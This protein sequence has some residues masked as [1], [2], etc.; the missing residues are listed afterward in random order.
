[1]NLL[2]ILHLVSL[3]IDIN[4][5]FFVLGR[6]PR[7]QLNRICAVFIA[8][9]ATWSLC[10]CFIL[11]A[12][13]PSLAMLY[14]NIGSI[15]WYTAPVAS[16]W[17][18]LSLDSRDRFLKNKAFIVI[19]VI[20]PLFF[21]Y[22][23]WSGNMYTNIMKGPWGWTGSYELSIATYAYIFYYL[24][25]SAICLYL[26]A[27]VVL[28]AKTSRQKN[29]NR[30]LIV[31]GTAAIIF[32]T[33]T[34][35][36]LPAM[37]ITGFPVTADILFMIW[38][39]GIAYAVSRYRFMSLNPI[40]ASSNILEIISDSIVLLDME[41]KIV[42]TN[43]ATRAL[44]GLEDKELSGF[45]YSSIVKERDI[46]DQVVEEALAANRNIKRELTYVSKSGE[47]IPVLVTLSAVQD[48]ANKPCGFVVSALNMAEQRCA[49]QI[50][51]ESEEKYRSHFYNVNEVIFSYDVDFRINEV[52]PSVERSLG[53]RP[54]ELIGRTF[55]EL[56]IL[57]P[58]SLSQAASDAIH[59]LSGGHIELAEYQFIAKDG[60]VRFGE[61][62]GA[63]QTRDGKIV[64][65]ISV[66]RDITDRKLAESAREE[67]DRNYRL[68]AENTTDTVA[69][70]DMDLNI[71]WISDSSRETTGY[72]FE[73]QRALPLEKQMTAES[74]ERAMELYALALDEEKKGISP[75][76]RHYDIELEI[77]RKDGSTFWSENIFH[78]IREDQ[79]RA[80][81]ILM[82]GRDISRRKQAEEAL[83][84]EKH[85]TDALI[86][87]LP[88]TFWVVDDNVKFIRWNSNQEKVLGYSPDKLSRINPLKII[89][90]EDRQRVA[91]RFMEAFQGSCEEVETYVIKETGQ[92]VPYQLS[93]APLTVGGRQ[94]LMGF[95]I[96]ISARK[97]AESKLQKIMD[98][99]KRSNEELEQFAYVASHDLQE[100]L[101]MVSSYVQ[102]LEKRYRDKL[103]TDAIDFIN[104]AVDGSRRMQNL[105]NDLLSYSR[106]GS[107]GKP[108]QPVD[109]SAI[110]NAA[111]NNLQIAIRE[112]EAYIEHGELPRVTAD[113]GQMVQ[114]FKNLIGNAIKFH[115]KDSPHVIVNAD[116][117][118]GNWIFSVKDNGIGISRQFFDRIFM[119]FQRLHGN[120]YPGTGIGLSIA[121]K[122]IQRHGG[123]I[124][125]ES[126]LDKGSTFYFS[127]PAGQD[128]GV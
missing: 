124:W 60:S 50:I 92:T 89:V 85:F 70:I 96:D 105:I 15:S 67:S 59:V 68:L 28:K 5:I 100:P 8:I 112:N 3:L 42:F 23:Q 125:V 18:Y 55:L 72:S 103:D 106:V 87:N 7:A 65:V 61:V 35:V 41:R 128:G 20:L 66:A 1:M 86:D 63:A 16:V 29:L 104:F 99:L 44:L 30:I 109:S 2:L 78:F 80:T 31:T 94:Y 122:I 88:A 76:D 12:D 4:L 108:F 121:R 57:T 27:S 117:V 123:Q 118:N 126:E 48:E 82:Q 9:F 11:M 116:R 115:G 25:A 75:L 95:G 47:A 58:E 79:G 102:L 83:L 51:R 113:E 71:R 101:R 84:R 26:M 45:N 49:E 69:I 17:F 40:M 33:I 38:I 62:S 43:R 46:V 21:L 34:D 19:S 64:G 32:G 52:S 24:I 127:I 93:F 97:Q 6:N 98:D 53:Y 120:E 73:E 81:G 77:C 110:Y 10:E 91:S 114:V 13:S 56:N 90:P 36:V 14:A 74:M 54:E 119:V 22:Q 107:R 37:E 39:G 111:V